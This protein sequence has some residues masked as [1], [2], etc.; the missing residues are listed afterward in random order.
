M[1]TLKQGS[2]IIRNILSAEEKVRLRKVIS[3]NARQ[4]RRAF[5][6]LQAHWQTLSSPGEGWREGGG[7]VAVAGGFAQFGLESRL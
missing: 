7:A 5:M 2:V 1:C 3:A 6:K 4:P